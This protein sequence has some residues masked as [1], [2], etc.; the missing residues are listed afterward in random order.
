MLSIPRMKL[1]LAIG[2]G[3]MCMAVGNFCYADD[4]AVLPKGV[5]RMFLQTDFAIPWDKRF[6]SGGAPELYG[7]PFTGPL[8][9]TLIPGLP[10]GASFG[11]SAVD[12]ERSGYQL[13]FQP[14][15]GVTDR[16]SIGLIIPVYA[17]YNNVNP[18]VNSGPGS[19]ATVGFNPAVPGG[20]APLFV[21][22]TTRATVQDINNLLGSRFGLKPVQSWEETGIG[23]IE[24]GGRYQYYR[25]EIV[26]ASFTGGAR[27]PTGKTDDQDNLADSA[28]GKGTYGLLA[29]FQTDFMHQTDGLGKRLGFPDPGEWFIN[30]TARYVYNLPM[31]QNLRVCPGGTP[32]CNTKDDVHSKIGDEF[33][34]EIS[35]R[36]GMF[37]KGLNFTPLYM[38][39]HKFKDH[40]SG[41]KGLDYGALNQQ[42]DNTRGEAT[43]HILLLQLT[44]TTIPLFLEKQ[45]PAPLVFSVQ[46]RDRFAGSGGLP[47]NQLLGFTVQAFF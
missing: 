2:A 22:G 14:A 39:G 42:L 17:F 1:W 4:A 46:W 18:H 25:S 30:T 40:Y 21:P 26:R 47:K 36:L 28:F 10:P 6:N 44:Y 34:L 33:Q 16:L 23:D 32:F 45:L 43:Q 11:Q 7:Q 37:I 35:G 24:A 9:S 19:G 20:I 8:N 13:I 5:S 12:V 31:T 3:I 15:Y 41:D 29:Q 27:F 38:Y